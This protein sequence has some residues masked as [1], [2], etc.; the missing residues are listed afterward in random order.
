[1]KIARYAVTI[2]FS[3]AMLF[4]VSTG[5]NFDNTVDFSK[6]KTYRWVELKGGAEKLNEI[7]RGQVKAA[8]EKALAAKGL[9]R[10]DSENADLCIGYQ[11]GFTQDQEYTTFNSGGPWGYGPGWGRGWGWG[12]GMGG[13]SQT[14]KQT[15]LVGSMLLDLYE[16]SGKKLVW[17]GRVSGTLH[18]NDKPEKRL[19]NLDKALAKMM[20]N[21]P[22]KEFLKK[23]KG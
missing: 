11:L 6:Y 19:K 2:L 21:Y 15:I 16:T 10:I 22:P 14:T 3:A 13:I 17:Q 8:L 7:E 5:Y 23:Q 18:P 9:Q 12:G 1:M 20:K 4:A